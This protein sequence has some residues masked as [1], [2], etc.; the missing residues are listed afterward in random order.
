[1]EAEREDIRQSVRD[2]YKIKKKEPDFMMETSGQIGRKKKSPEE[3]AAEAK[4]EG[5]GN[6]ASALPAGLSDVTSKLG[7]G[8]SAIVS[9]VQEKCSLM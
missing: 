4:G 3:L 8:P 2:K 5:G 7:E 9:S 1:M 6:G